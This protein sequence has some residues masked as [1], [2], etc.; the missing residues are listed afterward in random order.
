MGV[1]GL[2]QL[3]SRRDE[4]VAD[5]PAFLR[6]GLPAQGEYVCSSCGY[7]ISVRATLPQC[8]MCRGELWEEPATSPYALPPL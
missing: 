7:G 3:E 8:P 6:A 2:M 1:S 4:A 5:V